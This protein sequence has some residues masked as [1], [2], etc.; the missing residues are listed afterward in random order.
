MCDFE[1]FVFTCG[2]NALDLKD[3]CH[4]SR[5][6]PRHECNNVKRL[7]NSWYQGRPCNSCANLINGTSSA[8]GSSGRRNDR[9]D[10]RGPF[11]R[12]NGGEEYPW[13]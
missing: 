3:Y 12:E 4:Q 1:E 11:T 7:R 9:E 10:P 13:A 5:N 6:H 8:S 2:H